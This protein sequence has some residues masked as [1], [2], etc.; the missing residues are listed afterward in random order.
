MKNIRNSLTGRFL[1]FM[2][3]GSLCLGMAGCGSGGEDVQQSDHDSTEAVQETALVT[4]AVPTEMTEE[5]TTEAVTEP[6]YNEDGTRRAWITAETRLTVRMKSTPESDFIGSFAGREEIRLLEEEIVNGYYHVSGEDVIS[7]NEITGY[8]SADYISLDPPPPPQVTL[9]VPEY[10]QTDDR[11]SGMTLGSTSKTMYDIGCATTALAMSESFLKKETI[12]PDQIAENAVYTNNGELGWP[13]DYYWFYTK[14]R[15]LE[16]AFN[17]LHEGIP[18]LIGGTRAS[19]NPHWVLITGYVG[20][21][22]TLKAS[23]FLINDPMPLTRKTLQDYLDDF[24]YFSKLI[25]YCGDRALVEGS[26]ESKAAAE[27]ESKAKAKEEKARK[28]AEKERKKAEE[29][30][31]KAEEE[32][33]KAAES[34]KAESESVKAEESAKAESSTEAE[35]KAEERTKSE[36][37]AE[38]DGSTEEGNE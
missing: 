25:Y 26:E 13:K 29:A 8:A 11:W 10:K 28:K 21:G 17:K 1:C 14:N 37:G 35:S 19:G 30:S 6:A 24:P 4:E 12:Y 5:S 2:L 33:A 22:E 32:A 36:N 3:A 27:S 31:R 38:S 9:E 16:F 34:A 7:G 18:V 15:Y 20:D 23:D